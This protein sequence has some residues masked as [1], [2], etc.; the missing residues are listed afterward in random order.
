MMKRG[1]SSKKE[2]KLGIYIIFSF[3]TQFYSYG[4]SLVYVLALLKHYSTTV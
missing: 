2:Y 1:H 3:W 4:W